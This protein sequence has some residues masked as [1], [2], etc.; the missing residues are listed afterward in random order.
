MSASPLV[1]VVGDEKAVR[2]A[3]AAL[4]TLGHEV[5]CWNSGAQFLAGPTPGPG[6]TILLDLD[7]PGMAAFDIVDRL[8]A[9][10]VMTPVIA[11]AGLNERR[12]ENEL[13]AGGAVWVLHTPFGRDELQRALTIAQA[14]GMRLRRAMG[15][16]A[17]R[18][19]L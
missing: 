18:A 10:D 6:D 16:E 15:A 17:G 19:A 11:I 13:I 8:R 3:V 2:H 12:S 1:H 4:F 9:W 7:I 5:S 14:A